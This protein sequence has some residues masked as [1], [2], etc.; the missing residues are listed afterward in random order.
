MFK[1]SHKTYLYFLAC[2]IAKFDSRAYLNFYCVKGGPYMIFIIG[3]NDPLNENK[4][5]NKCVEEI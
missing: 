5:E 2:L 3:G 1:E 4:C